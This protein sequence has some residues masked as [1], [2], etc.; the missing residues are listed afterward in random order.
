MA[1]LNFVYLKPDNKQNNIVVINLFYT[2]F[3]ETG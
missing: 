2:D 3:S 1:F